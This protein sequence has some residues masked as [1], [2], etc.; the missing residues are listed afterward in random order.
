MASLVGQ[1]FPEDVAFM[2]VPFVAE[3]AGVHEI[4]GMP[5]KFDASK[6]IFSLAP[7]SQDLTEHTS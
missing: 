2:H 3:K 4:C 7:D 6:G 1:D 5:V